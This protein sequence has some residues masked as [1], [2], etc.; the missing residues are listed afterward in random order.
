MTLYAACGA[1]EIEPL[2]PAV[3]WAG[4]MLVDPMTN[5]ATTTAEARPAQPLHA[6]VNPLLA[7]LSD[8]TA[9]Q[10]LFE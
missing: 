1:G 2:P 7:P 9:T 6:R 8:N 3:A 4:L 5:M 10:L